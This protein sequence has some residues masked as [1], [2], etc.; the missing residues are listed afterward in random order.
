MIELD[1]ESF[2]SKYK[3]FI[4]MLAPFQ[5]GFINVGAYSLAGGFF[6]SHVTGTSSMTA[7]GIARLDPFIFATFFTVLLSFILGAGLSGYFIKYKKEETGKAD[8]ATVMFIKFIFF[9]I[10]LILSEF[11]VFFPSR[12]VIEISHILMLFLLS[13]CCGVQNSSSSLATGGFLKPTHMTG[14]STDVGIHLFRFFSRKTQKQSLE[15]KHTILRIKILA[16]FIIGGV[17]SEVIFSTQGH[18]GWI[19]PFLSSMFFFLISKSKSNTVQLTRKFQVLKASLTAVFVTTIAV[20]V[21]SYS[22]Y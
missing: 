8:Y 11:D 10:I 6:V 5:A 3:Q 19:F 22:Q 14:L 17:F 12:E 9:G 16:S 4:W 13:F 18:Y 20:G 21:V 1:K 15:Y 7:V 2:S